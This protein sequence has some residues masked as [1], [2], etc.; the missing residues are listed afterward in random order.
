MNRSFFFQNG[1]YFNTL[2]DE[3]K[4]QFDAIYAY[5]GDRIYRKIKKLIT[6]DRA[7]DVF[8]SDMLQRKTIFSLFIFRS[9]MFKLVIIS[10]HSKAII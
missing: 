5:L 10:I 7:T 4:E 9:R 8:E 3:F 1:N 6:L 2:Y